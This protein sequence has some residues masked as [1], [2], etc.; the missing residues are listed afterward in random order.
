MQQPWL[1]RFS[2]V[3]TISATSAFRIASVVFT[4]S[5]ARGFVVAAT[6]GT[7]HERSGLALDRLYRAHRDPPNPDI[8][9]AILRA[10]HD[11]VPFVAFD[12][13]ARTDLDQ[14]LHLGAAA[15]LRADYALGDGFSKALREALLASGARIDPIDQRPMCLGPMALSNVLFAADGSH[16][17]LGFGH[18]VVVHDE[19]RVVVAR[20]R[21]FQAVEVAVGQPP[22]PISDFVGLLEMTRAVVAW[23]DMPQAI[24]RVLSG[25]TLRED[26]ELMR[27]ALW[28]ER[29]VLRG[30]PARR[31]PL[32]KILAM[33]QRVRDLLGVVPDR[34]GFRS[35]AHRTIA[36][37]RPELLQPTRSVAIAR[38]GSWYVFDGRRVDLGRMRLLAKLLLALARARVEMPGTSLDADA[39]IAIG[40]S[41]EKMSRESAVNR[42]YVAINALRKSGLGKAIEHDSSGYR[43]SLSLHVEIATDDAQ[44]AGA[45]GML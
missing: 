39:L 40:W 7:N 42:L 15:G 29:K 17:V 2:D 12:F 37:G 23:V 45:L 9:H 33:S 8:A 14:L 4:E 11:G 32:A 25:N 35:L 20:G 31:P 22:T 41:D 19:H 5:G 6:S 1:G 36:A 27:C 43:I 13:P 28:F 21:V 44:V 26:F 10:E 3:E 16:T 34:E 38:D 18:N 30:S 24:R